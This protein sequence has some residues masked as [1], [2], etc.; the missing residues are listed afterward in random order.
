MDLDKSYLLDPSH[1]CHIF[2]DL[3]DEV[4]D[5]IEEK[6]CLEGKAIFKNGKLIF[7]ED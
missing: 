4:I 5:R 7:L 2:D 1:E 6:A 3:F